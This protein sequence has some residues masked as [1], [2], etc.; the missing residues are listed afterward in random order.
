M[1]NGTWRLSAALLPTVNAS[2][3]VGIQLPYLD[4]FH[5]ATSTESWSAFNFS[6]R[7]SLRRH[8]PFKVAS[9]WL[10][11][12]RDLLN[13]WPMLIMFARI[14]PHAL[15]FQ[16]HS[17]PSLIAIFIYWLHG[18]KLE[19]HGNNWHEMMN[20]SLYTQGPEAA[21][22]DL[23]THKTAWGECIRVGHPFEYKETV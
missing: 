8:G 20:T 11:L 2:L 7:T 21:N 17:T 13:R 5:S 10:D 4:W 9:W 18:L 22:W 23:V 3:G 19:R 12:T 1:K 15:H 6:F 16:T 14:L